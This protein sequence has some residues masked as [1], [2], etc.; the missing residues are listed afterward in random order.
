VDNTVRNAVALARSE[1]QDMDNR[2]EEPRPGSPYLQFSP[3]GPTIRGFETSR[4]LN[5]KVL[6][7]ATV[8]DSDDVS[9]GSDDHLHM[10]LGDLSPLSPASHENVASNQQ[11]LV[12]SRSSIE[13][14]KKVTVQPMI[15]ASTQSRGYG[16]ETTESSSTVSPDPPA[17]LNGKL[18]HMEVVTPERKALTVL[19]SGSYDEGSVKSASTRSSENLRS[20]MGDLLS[21]EASDM[22]IPAEKLTKQP[23]VNEMALAAQNSV[24]QGDYDVA[25]T[26]FGKVLDFYLKQYGERHPLV[27][28]AY[29]NMGMV[30]ALRSDLLLE[31][32]LQ[33]THVRQQALEC[34][35]RAARTARDSLGKNHPNVAVSLVKIGFLLLQERQF[36]PAL[37]TFEEALRIRTT[38]YVDNPHHPLIANLHNN[39]GTFL[40]P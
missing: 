9:I 39:I 2:K 23:N 36:N 11:H 28:S 3:E 25:L 5:Q 16:T 10:I 26:L 35:Q 8:L 18:K 29:H 6:S 21:D 13:T 40:E 7:S 14:T 22:P 19:R 20:M 4:R 1:R 24:E 37:V 17:Y 27:A 34:F 30:H 31:G 12:Q 33:Q 32:T 38:H 15:R